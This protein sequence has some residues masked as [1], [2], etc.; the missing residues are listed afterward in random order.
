M[1]IRRKMKIKYILFKFRYFISAL[2]I[3][4]VAMFIYDRL[5][6]HFLT[7]KSYF[8]LYWLF[9]ELHKSVDKRRLNL[10]N[11]SCESM[12]HIDGRFVIVVW[13]ENSNYGDMKF[14]IFRKEPGEQLILS[15]HGAHD[16]PPFYIA[17]KMRAFFKKANKFH[18]YPESP[19]Y[20]LKTCQIKAPEPLTED[21]LREVLEAKLMED[22]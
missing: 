4:P 18:K 13:T 19:D 14:S 9:D 12:L 6:R 22:L 20:K 11:G 10:Y 8:Y 5:H 7:D 21:L 16:L 3:L 15:T 2:L 1:I 17:C